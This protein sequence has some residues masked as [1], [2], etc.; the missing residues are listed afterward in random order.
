MAS[1]ALAE[2]RRRMLIDHL[3][4]HGSVSVGDSAKQFGVSTETIRKDLLLLERRGIV[5]KSFGGAVLTHPP[6]GGPMINGTTSEPTKSAKAL[7]AARAMSFVAEGSTILVDG[8]TTTLGMSPYLLQREDL[9]IFT[10]SVPL[11][12]LLGPSR[13]AVFAIGGRLRKQTMSNVGPWAVRAI[14]AVSV[15][16]AFLGTDGLR[17]LSGPS[18]GSY[19]ESEFKSAALKA[20]VLSIVLSDSSKFALTGV[21]RFCDWNNVDILLTDGQAPQDDINRIGAQTQVVIA[22]SEDTDPAAP[23]SG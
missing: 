13:S 6:T 22:D 4:E 21:F 10:N 18:T 17:G 3:V 5:A 14:E 15:D 7:I 11:L 2:A 12:G 9:T 1:R 19:E 8:G 16:V 23:K 20:S